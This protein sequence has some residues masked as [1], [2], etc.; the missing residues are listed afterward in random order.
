MKKGKGSQ[1]GVDAMGEHKNPPTLQIKV[2]LI[3]I[4]TTRK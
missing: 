1:A 2:I 3:A 4:C